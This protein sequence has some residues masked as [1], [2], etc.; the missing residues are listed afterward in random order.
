VASGPSF[1]PI[2]LVGDNIAANDQVFNQVFPYSA[3]PNAGPRNS[4]DSGPNVGN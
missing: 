2:I 4:K 3:T 1:N